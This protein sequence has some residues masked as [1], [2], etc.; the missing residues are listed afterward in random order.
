MVAVREVLWKCKPELKAL[1]PGIFEYFVGL[2]QQKRL[3][4]NC[5]KIYSPKYL[6]HSPIS[7]Q[8]KRK[9]KSSFLHLSSMTN[10]W[11]IGL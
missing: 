8:I 10:I 1:N 4:E 6:V 3:R 9:K 5:L 2:F 11:T 7:V